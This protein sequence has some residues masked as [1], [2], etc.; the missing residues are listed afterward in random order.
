MRDFQLW[1]PAWIVFLTIER[2]FSLTQVTA[3]EGL[4]LIGVLILEVPTGAVADRYGRSKSMALGAAVL[5]GAVLIFAFTQSFAVLLASFLLWSVA[6]ALM[7]GADMALLFDTLKG[8]RPRGTV[9]AAGRARDGV[10][11]VGRRYRD[12][13]RRAGGSA[14]RHQGDRIHRRRDMPRHGRGCA[15]H[16]GAAA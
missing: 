13:S 7:S 16:L 11:L 4:Y 5:G 3:A 15:R 12:V 9:R 8:R 14:A 6:S 10:R 1:I 2:G